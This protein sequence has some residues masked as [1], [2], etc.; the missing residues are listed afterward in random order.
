MRELD[1]NATE[2]MF[3]NRDRL[4]SFVKANVGSSPEPTVPAKGLISFAHSYLKTARINHCLD[5]LVLLFPPHLR[6][7]RK[8]ASKVPPRYGTSV[9]LGT[10]I[11]SPFVFGLIGR[12]GLVPIPP[13]LSAD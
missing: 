6:F 13:R 5:C 9:V 12:V 7:S 2:R 4:A 8:R 11:L 1:G 10:C 3:E